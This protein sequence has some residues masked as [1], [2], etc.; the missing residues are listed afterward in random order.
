[1]YCEQ[2]AVR[3]FLFGYL[4]GALMCRYTIIGVESNAFIEVIFYKL[5]VKK[6]YKLMVK[7]KLQPH[8]FGGCF[9]NFLV[10]STF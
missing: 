10:K 6:A 1:M 4:W 9:I 3:S 5:L 2:G 7:N 8:S